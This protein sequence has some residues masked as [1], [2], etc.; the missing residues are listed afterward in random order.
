MSIEF[1]NFDY[2]FYNSKKK[3]VFVP[4][5]R[6][7]L[8]A[9]QII[10]LVRAHIEFEDYYFH[11]SKG[12]HVAALHAH[13]N[14]RYFC[15]IDLKNFFYSISRN[16][17]KAALKAIGIAE[18]ERFAKWSTVKNPY[19]DPPYALPYGFPQSPIL[20][21]LVFRKSQLGQV[22]DDLQPEIQRSV[23]IDDVAISGDDPAQLR[24]AFESIVRAVDDS[25]FRLNDEKVAP[26]S[27]DMALFNCDLSHQRSVVSPARVNMFEAGEH[28]NSGARAFSAY[29]ASVE[30]GN[31]EV[32]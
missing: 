15:R 27:S 1:K 23:Y 3:P 28:S 30:A 4:N 8:L 29:C 18:A 5:D 22:I 16:R 11:F 14:N 32:L 7:R 9:A 21:T 19:D 17:V 13:R 25:N 20:A 12:A 24:R 2:A 26:P 10:P 6:C 31:S